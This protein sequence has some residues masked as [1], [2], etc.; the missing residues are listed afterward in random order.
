VTFERCPYDATPISAEAFSGGSLMLTC[1]RCGAAWEAHNSLV[2]RVIEPA[3]DEVQAAQAERR[4]EATTG[5]EAQ[6]H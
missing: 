4:D 5:A 3:W 1:E 6:P 2:R